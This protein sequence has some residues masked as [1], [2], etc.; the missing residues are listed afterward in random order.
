MLIADLANAPEH[1]LNAWSRSPQASIRCWWCRWWTSKALSGSLVVMRKDARRILAPH[2]I[3][4]MRTFAHQS[5]LAML[6]ARLFTEVDHKGRQPSAAHATVQQQAAKLQEQTDQL[7]NLNRSLEERVENQ[8]AE[9]GRIS[10]LERF[11]RR[12]SHN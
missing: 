6:I 9:I 12:R 1:P 10:R 5:V 7:K 4:L 3:G 2:L 11:W 8:L